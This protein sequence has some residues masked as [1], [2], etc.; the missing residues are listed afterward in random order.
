[1][2]D[3]FG[4][5]SST[6]KAQKTA[7]D[8]LQA[9]INS[10][11]E[12]RS[13]LS[14]MLTQITV[15][16]SKLTQTH[17]ALEQI[18][19]MA[20]GTLDKVDELARRLN[21]LDERTTAMED[22]DKRIKNLSES[23]KLAQQ[24]AERVV[25]P[26]G[27]LQKHREAVKQLSS[28][29]LETQASLDTL[30]KERSSLEDLRTQLKQTQGQLKQSLDSASTLKTEL[31]Q[32]RGAAT[33]LSQDYARMREMSR[34]SRED[35]GAAMEAVKD[36]EKRLGPLAQLHELSKNTEE[37]LTS[38]NALAEHVTHTRNAPCPGRTWSGSRR[39]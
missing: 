23:V 3:A 21:S 30:K 4:I 32:V 34:E 19:T 17:K 38:L 29:T 36:V 14:E 25:G 16:A 13:A 33:I 6:K 5:G 35:S 9:L 8:E 31:E 26:E 1:M 27:D 18:E 28:Q 37:R 2:L 11:K 22:V 39:K 20:N 24:A 15:R 12:E 7:A 10:S